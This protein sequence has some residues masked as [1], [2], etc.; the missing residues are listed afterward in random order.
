MIERLKTKK[1]SRETGIELYRICLMFGICLFH[2]VIACG[3]N[4][5]ELN[6]LLLFTVVGFVA[7]SGWFGIRFSWRKI[8][9]LYLY[10]ICS[11]L[12]VSCMFG[13]GSIREAWGMVRGYWFLHAYIILMLFAPIVNRGLESFEGGGKSRFAACMPIFILVFVWSFLT[14]YKCVRT[15]LPCPAGLGSMSGY[16]LIGI[17]L[18]GRLLR[19]SN[20]HERITTAALLSAVPVLCCLIVFLKAGFYDSILAFLLAID[21][22][23][24][25]RRLDIRGKA[26]RIINFASPSMFVVYLIHTNEVI[27]FDYAAPFEDWLIV[28][29][30]LFPAYLVVGIGFFLLGF[31][32]SMPIRFIVA[33]FE[34][35]ALARRAYVRA[36]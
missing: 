22:L 30:G 14:E 26:A 5:I 21:L 36:S 31:L 24:I 17:Y 11:A 6:H 25:F 18:G 9:V 32:L 20:F 12:L 23:L 2:A 3:H 10:A 1:P 15:I 34:K 19:Y 29:T 13:A 16:T 27:L 35:Y 33:L 28:R 8:A 4:T 7:I